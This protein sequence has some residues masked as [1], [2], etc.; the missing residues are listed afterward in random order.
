MQT[1]KQ[2]NGTIKVYTFYLNFICHL[3]NTALPPPI[4]L[5]LNMT[6][7]AQ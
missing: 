1:N 6:T 2:Y 3:F 5:L 4:I 7:N